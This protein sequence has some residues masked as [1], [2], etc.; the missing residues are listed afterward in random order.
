MCTSTR[1]K[2]LSWTPDRSDAVDFSY[3]YTSRC[4]GTNLQH[5][6]LTH[7]CQLISI[8]IELLAFDV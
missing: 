5:L 6:L 3:E 7:S 4:M 2:D 1:R 8:T